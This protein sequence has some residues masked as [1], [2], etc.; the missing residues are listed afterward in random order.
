MIWQ[1]ADLV[2]LPSIGPVTVGHTMVLTRAHYLSFAHVP[3]AL[4]HRAERVA[5]HLSERIGRYGAVILFEHGPMSEN[6][7]GGACT[8]HAHLHC[9]PIGDVDIRPRIEERLAGRRIESLTELAQQAE[10]GQ[11]YVF[12]RSQHGESWVYDVTVDLPCQFLR[13]VAADAVGSGTDWDWLVCPR[14]ELVHRTLAEIR[15]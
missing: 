3:E 4:A 2:V 1:D 9:L 8:D 7:L 13:R 15:W 6:A 5:G 10:R 14:P 12:Y 11:P